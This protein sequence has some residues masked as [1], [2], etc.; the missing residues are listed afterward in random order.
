MRAADLWL[1]AVAEEDRRLNKWWDDLV[2]RG[3]TS[4]RFEL[5]V[6]KRKRNAQ[7]RGQ[8]A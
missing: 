5:D 2:A 6:K 3:V 4:S 1:D 8:S 7:R